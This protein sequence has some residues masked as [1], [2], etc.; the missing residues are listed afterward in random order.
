MPKNTI[1]PHDFRPKTPPSRPTTDPTKL[2]ATPILKKESTSQVYS[3]WH[4]AR[5]E[6]ITV[7]WHEIS[8]RVVGPVRVGDFLNRY[9]PKAPKPCPNHHTNKTEKKHTT[10]SGSKREVDMY[11]SWIDLVGRFCPNLEL[12]DAHSTPAVD[13]GGKQVKPDIQIYSANCRRSGLSDMTQTEM[14]VEFKLAR[15]DDAFKD[16]NGPSFFEHSSD[17]AH[18]TLGQITLYATAHQAAQFRTHVF[19]VL[20]FPKYARFMRWDRSGVIVTE[21]VPFSNP[22]YVEFFWRFNH[23]KPDVRGVDTTVTEFPHNHPVA[24]KAKRSLGVEDGDRLFQVK[25]DAKGDTYVFCCPTYMAVGSPLGRSTR[26]FKAYCVETGK[27]VLLKDTWRVVSP[28]QSPE[29]IIYEELKKHG[30]R[31]VCTCKEGCD[32]LDQ[33]TK[34]QDWSMARQVSSRLRLL[35]HYRL[36]LNEIARSLTDFGNTKEMVTAV[37]DAMIGHGDAYD[38][39]KI[40]HRDISSG[41]ILITDSGGGLLID[42]DLCKRLQDIYQGEAHIERTGT[43]QFMAAQLLVIPTQGEGA[44]IPDRADDLESFFYVLVWIALRYTEHGFVKGA[45]ID[46]LH[47]GFDHHYLD[48]QGAAKGG[49]RK[50][51]EVQAFDPFQVSRLFNVPLKELIKTLAKTIA[52]R[53]GEVP[54]AT[55]IAQYKELF[56]K[57]G[58]SD[59]KSVALSK[60]VDN[61]II[62]SALRAGEY[63]DK[64]S[65]LD[66]SDWMELELTTAL[67]KSG[68]NAHSGRVQ[69]DLSTPPPTQPMV[70]KREYS[71]GGAGPIS[72]NRFC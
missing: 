46:M 57:Q 34:T 65:A 69:R 50:K 45:L 20:V 32:V 63:L 72:G 54:N 70:P 14:I 17:A 35:R 37:R 15:G 44:P 33:V 9:L 51:V 62:L 21:E 27:L 3:S 59:V 16:D 4:V 25:V 31:N 55:E 18:D 7:M 49:D 58:S 6:R 53:Y 40:L 1:P 30:V 61:N 22:S 12:V 5:D 52:V 10:F 41:N 28:S 24:V 48:P 36:V 47:A 71:E 13:F 19:L 39:A 68:W 38:R 56:E 64:L 60:P 29:H 43:W 23:A 42:W 8:G 2:G 66:R 11:K 67:Q 26:V